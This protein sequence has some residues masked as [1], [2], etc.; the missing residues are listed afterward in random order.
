MTAI[1]KEDVLFRTFY[2]L[3]EVSGRKLSSPY[4][5][6]IALDRRW[7]VVFSFNDILGANLKS[8]R[9]DYALS[10]SPYGM[11]Q[12]NLAK[13]LWLNLLMYSVTLDYKDDAIHLPH[14][15]RKR[16]R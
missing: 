11:S 5:E 1:S 10:V 7:V 13:R 16:A 8:A 12:R 2:L 9:G 4:L 14:I 15:L 6:G 3:S